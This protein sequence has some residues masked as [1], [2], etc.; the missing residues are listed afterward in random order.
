MSKSEDT[1][2]LAP[3]GVQKICE[4]AEDLA[5]QDG[6]ILTSV[7]LDTDRPEFS[8]CFHQLFLSV[9]D[10]SV[11]EKLHHEELKM[12]D[13]NKNGLTKTKI[14]SAIERLKILLNV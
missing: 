8:T 10:H 2:L 9:G 1:C 11:M 14:K 3:D 4:L 6:I 12:L 5:K 7:R 13:H